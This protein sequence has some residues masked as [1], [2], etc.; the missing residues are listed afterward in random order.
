[1]VPGSPAEALE[2]DSTVAIFGK[3]SREEIDLGS[4]D[5]VIAIV[6]S[7]FFYKGQWLEHALVLKA[8]Q[9]LV[10]DF[11]NGSTSRLR[12]LIFCGA[13]SSN[14]SVA[15]EVCI[16]QICGVSFFSSWYICQ[17][18]GCMNC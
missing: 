16:A 10:L 7:Q 5:F 4:G 14:Y 15:L 18:S 11:K 8:I 1:M 13:S 12:V 6:G 17:D 2:T 3:N 9:P